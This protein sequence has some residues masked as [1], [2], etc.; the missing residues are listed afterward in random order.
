MI[1]DNI[2]KRKQRQYWS[3]EMKAAKRAMGLYPVG[4]DAREIYRAKYEDAVRHF[5][6]LFE[7]EYRK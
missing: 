5:N 1:Y 7:D 3:A 2:P 6:A 4:S